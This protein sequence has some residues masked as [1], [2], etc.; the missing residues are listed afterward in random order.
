MHLMY[1][2][3]LQKITILLGDQIKKT[4]Q[5][6]LDIINVDCFGNITIILRDSFN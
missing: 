2:S 6:L 3:Y 5:K 1:I 4:D